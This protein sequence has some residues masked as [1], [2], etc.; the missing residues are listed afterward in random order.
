[1]HVRLVHERLEALVLA[2][3]VRR[4]HQREILL[5]LAERFLQMLTNIA[6]AHVGSVLTYNS[7]RLSDALNI[8]QQRVEIGRLAVRILD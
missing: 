5:E 6:D 1:M 4:L 7:L 8:L 3:A 2:D